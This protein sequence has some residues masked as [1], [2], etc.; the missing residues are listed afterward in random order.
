LNTCWT[1][2]IERPEYFA[3]SYSDR[4]CFA[5]DGCV[6]MIWLAN[7]QRTIFE[8]PICGGT[9]LRNETDASAASADFLIFSAN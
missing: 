3:M 2:A 9:T 1:K 4:P 7:K 5:A 8:S 6:H